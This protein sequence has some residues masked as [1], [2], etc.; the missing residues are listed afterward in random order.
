MLV[1]QEL[2]VVDEGGDAAVQANDRI[3]GYGMVHGDR[4]REWPVVSSSVL[5]PISHISR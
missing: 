4:V 3:S 2:E 5:F 1:T